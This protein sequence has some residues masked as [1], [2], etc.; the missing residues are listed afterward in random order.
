VFRAVESGNAHYGVVPIE[1][2]TE[3]AIGRSLDLLLS[4]PLKICGEINLPIHHQL[5]AQGGGL[6]ELTRIYSHAQSLAQCHEW[7]NRNLP[8]MLRVPVASNAEAARLAASEP[9]A[10]AIAGDAAAETVRAEILA[11]NIEDDP[12][13]TTRFAVVPGTMPAPR[14]RI[15][16]RWCVR[17]R[18]GRAACITCW[19][20]L[21]TTASP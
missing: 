7:L 18:T 5:M 2:S 9:G 17:R 12:N 6:G 13:N 3:G 16:P 11:G 21:P 15:A 14:A 8:Q 10:A 4:S 20:R 19:P 1:N